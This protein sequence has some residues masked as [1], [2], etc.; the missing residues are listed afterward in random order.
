MHSFTIDKNEFLERNIDGFYHDDYTGMGNPGNPDYIND[1]KNTFGDFPKK[2]LKKACKNLYHVLKND[3]PKFKEIDSLTICVVPRAKAENTYTNKQLLFKGVVKIIINELGFV[4]GS[5]YITRNTDT[6]TT[7]LSHTKYAGD[8]SM[9]YCGITKDTC[10]IS[11]NVK[12]KEI[13]LIDDLYTKTVNI[14]EDAIQALLDSGAK[15]VFFYA[16]GRTV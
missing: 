14:N 11:D 16:I 2:K 13:L 8:G 5:D 7:H 6:K 12:G 9:P 15:K 4:D 3:L 10:D 1:I